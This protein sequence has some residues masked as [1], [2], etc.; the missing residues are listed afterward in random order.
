MLFLI[1]AYIYI[2]VYKRHATYHPIYNLKSVKPQPPFLFLI[3]TYIHRHTHTH[4]M[5]TFSLFVDPVLSQ[6]R[7]ALRIQPPAKPALLIDRSQCKQGELA[8]LPIAH[9][10]E[11]P[12]QTNAESR[13]RHVSPCM[14]MLEVAKIQNDKQTSLLALCV[15]C[16]NPVTQLCSMLG[17]DG[18]S[19]KTSLFGNKKF[20]QSHVLSWRREGREVGGEG[21][22]GVRVG[23]AGDVV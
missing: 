14:L 4:T 21:W 3:H 5:S 6:I 7:Q 2:Y 8:V 22:G 16:C 12:A 15:S 10:S 9:L 1:Y 11:S 23:E 18:L 13:R 20:P 19:M 17:W